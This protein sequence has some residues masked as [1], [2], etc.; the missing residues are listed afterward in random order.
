MSDATSLSYTKTELTSAATYN[1]YCEIT[2]E[3]GTVTSR[4]ATLTVESS[5]PVYSFDGTS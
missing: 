3:A 4:V 1:V 5:K 2:N